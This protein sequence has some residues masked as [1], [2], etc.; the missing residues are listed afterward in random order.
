MWMGKAKTFTVCDIFINP[1][2]FDIKFGAEAVGAGAV[3][4]YGSETLVSSKNTILRNLIK[5]HHSFCGINHDVIISVADL[6]QVGSGPFLVGSGCLRPDP[7][8]DK[9]P[10]LHFFSVN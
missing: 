4:R 10:D 9:Q 8:L 2:V 1:S 6:D 7:G 5:P 3:M